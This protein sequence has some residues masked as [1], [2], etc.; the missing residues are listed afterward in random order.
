[1]MDSR[2]LSAVVDSIRIRILWV[3][4]DVGT[5]Q[6]LH[7]VQLHLFFASICRVLHDLYRKTVCVGVCMHI[8]DSIR[9][10]KT[11]VFFS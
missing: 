4:C 3:V 8:H 2:I 9:F 5:H 1:M 11:N 6:K 7:P 10:C